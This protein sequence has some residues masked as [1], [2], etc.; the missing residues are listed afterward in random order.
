LFAW[1]QVFVWLFPWRRDLLISA[2]SIDR[3]NDGAMD[4]WKNG[5]IDR[6]NDGM[7]DEWMNGSMDEWINGSI[8]SSG[9]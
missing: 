1:Q 4:E 2:E 3:W 8:K 9:Q 7:M 6:W 5:S